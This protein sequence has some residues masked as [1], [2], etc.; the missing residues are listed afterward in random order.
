VN[1]NESEFIANL[2]RSDNPDT[3]FVGYYNDPWGYIPPHSYGVHAGPVAALLRDYGLQAEARRGLAWD[4]L[5]AEVAAGRPVIVWIIGQM[6][7]GTPLSYVDSNGQAFTVAYFEHTMVLVGYNTTTV[8]VVDA[9]SGAS[10]TYYLSTFLSSWAVLGN[11]AILG[12]GSRVSSS[13]VDTQP[14]EDIQAGSSPSTPGTDTYLVQK[15]DYLLALAERFNI[16]WQELTALNDIP[17]PYMIYPGQVL[18]VPAEVI[19]TSHG[20]PPTELNATANPVYIPLVFGSLL[21]S[22]MKESEPASSSPETY[23]VRRG[24]FLIELAGRFGQDWQTL[25]FL[26]NI[27]YPYV[28]YPGQVLKLR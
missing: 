24:D 17:Y 15:G 23:T 10:Q 14:G 26:N 6:W 9:Y 1:I 7:N 11:M 3:G 18:K 8:F 19:P 25:A 21:T 2:L 27:Q 16:D 12:E 28:I 13:S 22:E 20:T 5:R 4:D